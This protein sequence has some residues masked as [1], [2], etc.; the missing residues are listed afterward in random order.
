MHLKKNEIK[1]YC[2][3]AVEVIKW[4]EQEHYVQWRI[5]NEHNNIYKLLYY[6]LVNNVGA[7]K[8][9]AAFLKAISPSSAAC[10]FLSGF[11]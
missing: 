7:A 10:N 4:I 6:C 3:K 1:R 2:E 5:Q 9:V 11:L 8:N